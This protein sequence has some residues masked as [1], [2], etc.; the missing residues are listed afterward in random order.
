MAEEKQQLNI[1]LADELIPRDEVISEDDMA[2]IKEMAENG[3]MYG[4]KKTRSNPKFR[5]YIFTTRNNIEIIDLAKTLKAID[6]TAVFLKSQI[7]ENK[8]V[9]L[10]GLQ[11]ASWEAVSR[12]AQKFNFP[13]VKNG[14]VG[15]L[16]TNFKIISQRLEQLR[17]MKLDKEKGEFEK[18]T[19]KE[20]VMINKEIERMS[21]MFEG[22]EQL[23]KVP[24]AIFIIDIS[25]KG[26]LTALRE[27][28]IA[29]I[30]IVAIIDSDDDPELVDYSI[31]ANDHTAKSI[32]WVMEKLIEKIKE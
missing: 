24:D 1:G 17:K 6:E 23:N 30:P 9:L 22:F 20:Q 4:H 31:P 2:V 25:L 7:A 19:K 28:K 32:S 16:I 12:F 18:Y 10:V 29:N 5:Q 3:V 13:S 21:E 8:N 26:H 11:P 14:W 15:G 27:A